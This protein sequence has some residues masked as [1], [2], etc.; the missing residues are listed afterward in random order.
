MQTGLELVLNSSDED[1]LVA[2][3]F[4]LSELASISTLLTSNQV[5]AFFTLLYDLEHRSWVGRTIGP[6]LFI[7][8]F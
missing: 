7:S 8:M 5:C 4:S 1:L 2:M 3:L 6:I